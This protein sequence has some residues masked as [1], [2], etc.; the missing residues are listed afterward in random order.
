[1]YWF[2]FWQL[3]LLVTRLAPTYSRRGEDFKVVHLQGMFN[4][5]NMAP[6]LSVMTKSWASR[7]K[8]E[9]PHSFVY[10]QRRGASRSSLIW[11]D[12][13]GQFLD[14]AGLIWLRILTWQAWHRRFSAPSRT[15]CLLA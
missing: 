4:W 13:L 3:R 7:R 15:A 2:V 6:K 14:L 10:T 12:W 5:Q 11:Q 8:V 1:M 9:A